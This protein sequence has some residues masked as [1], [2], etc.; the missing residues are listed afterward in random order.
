MGH[1][2]NV[3]AQMTHLSCPLGRPKEAP[4]SCHCL[5]LWLLLSGHLLFQHQIVGLCSVMYKVSASCDLSQSKI[6]ATIF[7]RVRE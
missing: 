2:C 7:H 1:G 3:S 4:S 5:L 6:L